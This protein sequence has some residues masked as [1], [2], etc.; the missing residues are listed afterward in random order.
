MEEHLS[1]FL[2]FADR[3]TNGFAIIRFPGGKPELEFINLAAASRLGS[4]RE[5]LLAEPAL[6]FKHPSNTAF[7]LKLLSSVSSGESTI[8]ESAVHT[9]VG[10]PYWLQ[11][12][13]WPL[14]K[15][16]GVAR[17]FVVT[18]DI[19]QRLKSEQ[20]L[21]LLTAG[22]EEANDG[23]A[24]YRIVNGAVS[25]SELVFCN[26]AHAEMSADG[27]LPLQA[28]PSEFN[29]RNM[30]VEV[31]FP[32]KNGYHATFELRV[33]LLQGSTAQQSHFV[34]V[35]RDIT[36]QR[37]SDRE[38]RL[39]SRAIDE[40]VDLFIITNADGISS[41]GPKIQFANPAVHALLERTPDELRGVLFMEL[42][43]P[44][45]TAPV[46]ALFA[47][48]FL[49]R[50]TI[51]VEALLISKSGRE[52]WCEIVMQP[53]AEQMEWDTHWLMVGRD[54]TLRKQAQGQVT[55]LLSIFEG[56][57]S[58]VVIY[59]PSE[60]GMPEVVY[61]NA[62]A[63]E[64]KRYFV[65]EAFT[66]NDDPALLHLRERL[67]AN[68]PLRAW[69]PEERVNDIGGCVE[70]DARAVFDQAGKITSIISIERDIPGVSSTADPG[71][72][73]TRAAIL[74]SAS[75]NMMHSTSR[76]ARL[77]T[78]SFALSEALDAKIIVGPS[79]A[80]P[81]DELRFDPV[82]RRATIFF[83]MDGARS[84]EITWAAIYPNVVITSLRLCLETFL[85]LGTRT[86]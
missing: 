18:T 77:R 11:M 14:P 28:L 12:T 24:I 75:Q 53:I 69:L 35:T 72:F 49:A 70:L 4:T 60:N 25:E 17:I 74:L 38:H 3:A 44:K 30:Y 67:L 41:D 16:S 37:E 21:G 36:E 8:A 47:Q 39:L 1:D 58:R 56:I 48:H 42:L 52:V 45:N 63:F 27:Y 61:E 34:A 68:A 29:G 57:D 59:E 84:G 2:A 9:L 33:L 40:S 20:H 5:A 62:A 80:I 31:Q 86:E 64:K 82:H 71:G 55:L 78:L 50:T 10:E 43:S 32:R 46:C 22:Y 19:T 7:A 81:P 23:I 76:T 65:Q 13:A 85:A 15:R 54:I 79:D 73:A 83:E 51:N 6:F 26:R 66:R